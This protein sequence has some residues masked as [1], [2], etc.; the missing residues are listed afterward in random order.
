MTL[1]VTCAI[2]VEG[3]RVLCTQRGPNMALAGEWEFPGG[4]IEVGE[5]EEACIVREIAEEL[6]LQIRLVACGP[7]SFFEYRPGQ[8][9]EL[10][11]FVAVHTGGQLLLREHAQARWCLPSEMTSLAWARADVPIVDWWLRHARDYQVEIGCQTTDE[12]Q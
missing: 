12:G 10:I 11:P 4:K 9:L 3:D 2:I 5:T 7:S 6:S 8:M 1:R